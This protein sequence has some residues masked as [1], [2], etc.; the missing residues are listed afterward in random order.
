MNKPKCPYCGAEMH[1]KNMYETVA[2]ACAC[3]AMSPMEYTEEAALAAA[4][5]RP[6]QK[7][8]T[9]EEVIE[10]VRECERIPLYYLPQYRKTGYWTDSFA[11]VCGIDI[12]DRSIIAT[13]RKV[14]G[15]KYVLFRNEP[16]EAEIEAVEWEK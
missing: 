5:R 4:L 9:F 7:P 2:F 14:Y 6:T 12:D 8:M 1:V 15:S 11:L 10:T 13:A 3:G 16:T